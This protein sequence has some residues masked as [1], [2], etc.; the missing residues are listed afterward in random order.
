M[1]QALRMTG[2]K[3]LQFNNLPVEKRRKF[4]KDAAR[5]LGF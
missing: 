5:A 1:A 4:R 2:L 3:A